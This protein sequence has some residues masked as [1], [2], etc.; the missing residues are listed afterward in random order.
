M[1]TILAEEN[2]LQTFPVGQGE[3]L[4]STP[5]PAWTCAS[6]EGDPGPGG[7]WSPAAEKAP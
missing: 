5:C 3:A 2:T 4:P 1:A 6:H 7:K